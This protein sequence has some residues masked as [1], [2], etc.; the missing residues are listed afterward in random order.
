MFVQ[1]NESY[2]EESTD[3]KKQVFVSVTGT[4]L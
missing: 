4:T 1:T 2:N 3:M